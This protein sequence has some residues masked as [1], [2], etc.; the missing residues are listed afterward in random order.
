MNSTL[1]GKMCAIL[2]QKIHLFQL[3]KGQN[4][5]G[6]SNGD[7]T[8]ETIKS[9]SKAGFSLYF[10]TLELDFKT[11]N[12]ADGNSVVCR[13]VAAVS[14]LANVASGDSKAPRLDCLQ[15]TEVLESYRRSRSKRKSER[16]GVAQTKQ[17]S[18]PNSGSRERTP[19]Q[20]CVREEKDLSTTRKLS[21]RQPQDGP[22]SGCRKRMIYQSQWSED[23][24]LDS[25]NTSTPS[26]PV[27]R[28]L[29]HGSSSESLAPT[30]TH[31][32]ERGRF[33]YTNYKFG[34]LELIFSSG[35]CLALCLRHPK[36]PVLEK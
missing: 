4:G 11:K 8:E 10:F 2:F 1:I 35:K 33:V 20:R 36:L 18:A 23:G 27:A 29:R 31:E 28:R 3:Q 26:H 14:F 25:T 6:D 32:R 5:G 7:A 15:N 22:A 30:P 21:Y 19:E 24:T 16:R 9:Y 13:R 12:M 17:R 34:F